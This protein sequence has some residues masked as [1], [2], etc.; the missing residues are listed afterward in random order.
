MRFPEGLWSITDTQD[1]PF[2]QR[3]R[4]LSK[5]TFSIWVLIFQSRGAC[6]CDSICSPTRVAVTFAT[7]SQISL[8]FFS[9]L[10]P[11]PC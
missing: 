2:I 3:L 4:Q 10:P 1:H 5:I 9:V 7:S 8:F 11:P 6:Q